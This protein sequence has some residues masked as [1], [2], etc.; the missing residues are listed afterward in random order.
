MTTRIEQIKVCLQVLQPVSLEIID[1]SQLHAGHAGARSGGGHYVVKICSAEFTA[2]NTM[3]RH[4]M[5][6]SALAE[7]LKADIHALTIDAKAPNEL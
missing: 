5:I 2:K 7:M 3:T 1:E 4:R 6:Y